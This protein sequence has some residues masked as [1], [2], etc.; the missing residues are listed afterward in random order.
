MVRMMV[1]RRYRLETLAF[2]RIDCGWCIRAQRLAVLASMRAELGS[3]L[4][5][6]FVIDQ[7]SEYGAGIPVSAMPGLVAVW[8]A[9]KSPREVAGERKGVDPT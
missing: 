7:L 3:R 8:M 2:L 9:R 5:A 6:E 1:E 4:F